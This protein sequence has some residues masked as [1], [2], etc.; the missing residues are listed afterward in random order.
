[1]NEMRAYFAR[2][3]PGINAFLAAEADRLDGLVRE[4]A[5][6]VLLSGGKRIRP[7][8]TILCART[9]GR[10][11]DDLLPMA[12]ALEMLHTATLLHDD[13]LD[14]AQTR[15]GKTSAHVAFGVTETILAGDVLLALANSL[16]AGYD[17]P[18]LNA[19]LARGIMAT[20]EGEILELAHTARPSVDRQAYLDIIIGKTARLIET[21]CR[22]GAALASRDRALEDLAGDF[23]LNLGIAFQLVDDALDYAVSESE[24]GKPA[25]GD[26][27]EGKMTLPLILYLESLPQAEASELLTALREK[28]LTVEEAARIVAEVREKGFADETREAAR[29]YVDAALAALGALP[30]TP[31]RAVLAQAAEYVLSRR[32]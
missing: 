3:I 10:A 20:A 8:L 11:E 2:E 22:C 32:K 17:I 18:R 21:A 13:V 9:L 15:R 12:C 16:G 4:V 28:R 30:E 14:Q 24:M 25:G 7:M 29:D 31:E 26:L 6:H 1:M 27:R 5:R 23:G 19:L